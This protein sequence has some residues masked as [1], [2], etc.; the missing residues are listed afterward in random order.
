MYIALKQQYS[1]W[2]KNAYLARTH[3]KNSTQVHFC[4]AKGQK[5]QAVTKA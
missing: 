2:T 1:S 4:E 5:Q 3:K